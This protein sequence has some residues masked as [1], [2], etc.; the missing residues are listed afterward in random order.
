MAKKLRYT[1]MDTEI[2][3]KVINIDPEKII[4]KLRQLD[5]EETAEKLLQRYVFDMESANSEWIRLRTD[6]QKTTITYKN[7]IKGNTAVGKTIEIEVEVADFDKTAQILSKMPFKSI[8]YQ[9]NKTHIFKLNGIE[10]S[11][12]TWPML[13]P[14]LEI[15]A[16][17]LEKVQEGLRLLGLEGQDIGDKD[18]KVIYQEKGIVL[19]AY[20]ELKF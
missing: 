20:P 17:S 12:D 13:E 10:F 18:V 11:I 9:E 5:A 19:H 8:F 1:N 3:T 6:G 4:A 16:E 15:E 2:E 7:K 14:Y